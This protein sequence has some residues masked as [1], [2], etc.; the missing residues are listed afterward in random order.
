MPN[1]PTAE[2]WARLRQE[3]PGHEDALSTELAGTLADG[4]EIL[5]GMDHRS[6]LHLLIPVN[7]DHDGERPPDLQGLRVRHRILAV[8]THCLDLS[9]TAAHERLFSPLASEVLQAVAA[10]GRD[11][12][13][14]V[15]SIVRSWQ[16]AWRPVA[17]E[18]SKTIQV[19]LFGE[20]LTLERIMLKALG[21]PVVQL[22]SGPESERHDFVGEAIHVEVKTTRRSRHE[23]EI[24]RLDQLDVSAGRRLLLV[25]ILLEESLAGRE[26]VGTKMDEII[27]LIRIDPAATDAFMSKMI[28]MGWS[29]ELRR[30]GQLVKFDLRDSHIFEVDGSFPRMPPGFIPPDG[31]VSV[32]YSIDL[33]NIPSIDVDEAIAMLRDGNPPVQPGT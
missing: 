12:W 18:M 11:P 24:S 30:S 5:F 4:R 13:K 16:S 22:W 17:P 8:D 23:H 7:G 29:D 2:L 26:T 31:V 14:A 19:G 27:E 3:R 25:S 20:L 21:P 15:T 33:A 9:A 28:R 32:R 10:V 1:A 6:D